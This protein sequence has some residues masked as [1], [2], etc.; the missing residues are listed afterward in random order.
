MYKYYFET[1]VTVSAK[2]PSVGR[3]R[4]GLGIVAKFVFKGVKYAVTISKNGVKWLWV[5]TKNGFKRL[6]R[7][8]CTTLN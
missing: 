5:K 7:G 8:M 3:K 2:L 1:R 6:G 4:R